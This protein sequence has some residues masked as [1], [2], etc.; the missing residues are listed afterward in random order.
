MRAGPTLRRPERGERRDAVGTVR[1]LAVPV[2]DARRPTACSWSPPRSRAE[3]DEVEDAVRLAAIVLL[4]RAADRVG[5]RLGGRRP[6][7]R[8]AA[9]AHRHRALDRR[10]RPHAPDPRHRPTTRSPSWRARSTRCSTG[11]RRAFATQR[12]VR[13]RR[14]PR[15]AHADHDRPRPPRAARRRPGRAARDGRARHRRARPDEPL[16]RRPAAAGQGR[17]RRLPARRRGRARRAHRRAAR[18]GARRSAPRDWQLEARGEALVVADRQ[19]LT[20]AIMGL[21][22]N[23]VQHT[24]RRRPDLDRQ[25]RP[26]ATRR[27]SGCATAARASRP[28]DQ[29]RI[30]ERFAARERE[31]AALGGRRARAGDRAR[32]RRGARRPRRARR[33]GP[34]P[35][36]P[37]PSTA[38]TGL[39]ARR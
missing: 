30:F 33:A 21:A 38:I 16:R 5:A 20:Q 27:G 15:A 9:A 34:A 14:Q 36:P 6:R 2:D 37:S 23:A 8:A 18:Q 32:D 12:A 29:E 13:Q 10:D 7:A 19:R 35:A 11:S 22:Q 1:Y 3:R 4:S 28:D 39:E 26:T 24:A 17:A 25:R 31:P